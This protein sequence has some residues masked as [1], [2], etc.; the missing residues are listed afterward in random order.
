MGH[1]MGAGICLMYTGT[2]P[3]KVAALCLVEGFVPLQELESRACEN[4]RDFILVHGAMAK[5]KQILEPS[6]EAAEKRLQDSNR[7]LTPASV[8]QLLRRGAIACDGGYKFT[9]DLR[10]RL[11]SALRLSEAMVNSFIQRVSCDV[12]LIGA[13]NGHVGVVGE[14]ERRQLD[15]LGRVTSLEIVTVPGTH[16]VHMNEPDVVAP[17]IV[18]FL[19]STA[20]KMDAPKS[21]L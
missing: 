21:K 12:M 8:H 4:L 17:H 15:L 1:S 9:R 6:M 14:R 20:E 13:D 18:R 5:K 2:F 7:H 16:H 10:V 11:P 3:E 19:A